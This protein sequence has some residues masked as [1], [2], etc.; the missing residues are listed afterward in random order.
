MDTEI[1]H[2][3][4]T[5]IKDIAERAGV[6]KGAVSY[7]LNGRPGVSEETRDRILAIAEELGWYP[8]RAARSLSA[9]RADACGLILARPAS[10]LAL[11]PFFMEFIAGVEACLSPRSIGLTIQLAGSVEEEIESYRRWFGEHRVDGVFIFDI[12]QNDTRAE[13]LKAIGLPAVVIGGPL[14]GH[15]LPAVWHDEASVVIEAVQYLAALGHRKIAR[16]AGVSEFVHTE[17]R[18]RAFRESVG[19]F[20]AESRRRVARVPDSGV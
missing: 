16:V 17:E 1:A 3:R 15:P 5:T 19:G 14:E 4:R 10:T 7:A 8:N 9:S 12:V 20:G 18:T 6:S 11:E 13:A 2:G